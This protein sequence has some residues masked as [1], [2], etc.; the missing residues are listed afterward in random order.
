MTNTNSEMEMRSVCHDGQ[1]LDPA[2]FKRETGGLIQP[3]SANIMGLTVTAT[4][5][6][7][8]HSQGCVAADY[9]KLHAA[10][11][12]KIASGTQALHIADIGNSANGTQI[13]TAVNA[14][15]AVVEAFGQ[16]ALS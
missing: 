12:A 5:L 13:A 3:I 10:S 2:Y 14:L 1:V 9:A 4:E 16:T 7:Y 11:G 15:I 8:I 6:N